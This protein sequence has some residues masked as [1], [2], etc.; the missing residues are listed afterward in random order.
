MIDRE[1]QVFY[2][3]NKYAQRRI[4]TTLQNLY[5]MFIINSPGF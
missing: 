5:K 2:S 4:D 3:N 1:N